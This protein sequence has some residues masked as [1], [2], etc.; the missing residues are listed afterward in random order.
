MWNF[1]FYLNET[2]EGNGCVLDMCVFAYIFFQIISLTC[3]HTDAF[4]ISSFMLK[5]IL[6]AGEDI[7]EKNELLNACEIKRCRNTNPYIIMS[8]LN[9]YPEFLPYVT[10]SKA[11]ESDHTH[12]YA[13]RN[14]LYQLMGQNI[15]K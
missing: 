2:V 11:S 10:S 8:D 12:I 13:T 14:S 7:A 4:M 3:V 5:G 1:L 15:S 6:R 9:F